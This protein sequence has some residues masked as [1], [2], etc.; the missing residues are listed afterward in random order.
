MKQR[1][2]IS[3]G[4]LCEAV[5]VDSRPD[6]SVRAR[7]RDNAPHSHYAISRSDIRRELAAF[8]DVCTQIAISSEVLSVFE[9][10][11]GSGWHSAFIQ[12]IVRPRKHTSIDIHP[13]CV[14]SILETCK[15]NVRAMCVDSYSLIGSTP[16]V[17]WVHCDFNNFDSLANAN[18]GELVP[19][20]QDWRL[21]YSAFNSASRWVT[22]TEVSQYRLRQEGNPLDEG[23]FLSRS[24]SGSS[25][26][27]LRASWCWGPATMHL[28][29]AEYDGPAV[30]HNVVRELELEVLGVESE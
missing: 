5:V 8:V 29:D 18:G 21:A 15:G 12:E 7:I 26:K 30:C 3:L 16:E 10:F 2:R 25:R 28:F 23:K 27:A 22:I 4:G 19:Y 14:A 13:D 17:D 24:L 9:L 20:L 1:T 6:K 11:G